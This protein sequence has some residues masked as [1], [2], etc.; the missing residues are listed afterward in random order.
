MTTPTQPATD[1][2]THVPVDRGRWWR[3]AATLVLLGA[4]LAPAA[5]DRDGLPLSTYPMYAHTRDSVVD[6]VAVQARASG[7]DIELS[8]GEIAATRDPLVAQSY[9]DDRAAAGRADE[10]C[11]E[12]ADRIGDDHPDGVDVVVARERHRVVDRARGQSSLEERDVLA[13][14]SS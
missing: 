4:L 2:H 1:T 7:A 14:C 6:I 11:R 3:W 12:S 5:L 9:L 13:R 8:I 10:V